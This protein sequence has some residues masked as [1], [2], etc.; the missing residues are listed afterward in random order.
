MSM[1]VRVPVIP[2]RVSK[3][4]RPSCAHRHRAEAEGHSVGF[5]AATL[6]D[7]D[8]QPL[9]YESHRGAKHRC[10]LRGRNRALRRN[11]SGGEWRS[12]RNSL[13]CARRLVQTSSHRNHP[14]ADLRARYRCQNSECPFY[15]PGPIGRRRSSFRRDRLPIP[16]T[17]GAGAPPSDRKRN[18][19]GKSTRPLRKS[20][21][22]SGARANLRG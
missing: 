4:R 10:S 18:A 13:D 7:H 20:A 12:F 17:G 6:R 2:P 9:R 1:I 5:S 3:R 19:N 11:W 21:V 8:E 22:R 14:H 15:F 16:R